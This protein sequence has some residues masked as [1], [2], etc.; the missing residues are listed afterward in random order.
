[1]LKMLQIQKNKICSHPTEKYAFNRSIFSDRA[2]NDFGR[3]LEIKES[4]K[5]VYA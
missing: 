5:I 3:G 1:M 2:E 4:D